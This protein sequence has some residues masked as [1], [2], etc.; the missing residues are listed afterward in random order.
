MRR[1]VVKH[2]FEGSK[3]IPVERAQDLAKT[4]KG[5]VKFED[6]TTLIGIG[7]KFKNLKVGDSL[8]CITLPS[9]T[10][11]EE[12]LIEEIVDETTIRLKKPGALIYEPGREYEA[13]AL[14]KVDQSDVFKHVE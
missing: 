2:L 8:K 1:P 9:E 7:T 10:K 5:K 6:P 14:P 3:A 12:Q 4:I 11:V 13:K